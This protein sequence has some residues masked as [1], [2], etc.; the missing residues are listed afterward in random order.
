MHARQ[1]DL[2]GAVVGEHRRQH[3]IEVGQRF[4]LLREHQRRLALVDDLLHLLVVVGIACAGLRDHRVLVLGDLRD[5]VLRRRRAQLADERVD[6]GADGAASNTHGDSAAHQLVGQRDQRR[7]V[8]AHDEIVGAPFDRVELFA[9]FGGVDARDGADGRRRGALEVRHKLA[10]H[11][12]HRLWAAVRRRQRQRRGVVVATDGAEAVAVGT[13]PAVDRLVRVTNG[14]QAATTTNRRRQHRALCG[15]KVL[16]FV[17]EQPVDAGQR[18]VQRPRQ[19]DLVVEVDVVEVAQALDEHAAG[20]ADRLVDEGP[21]VSGRVDLELRHQRA[22]RLIAVVDEALFLQLGAGRDQALRLGGTDEL[23]DHADE[24]LFLPA[25]DVLRQT[26]AH[27]A[28]VDVDAAVAGRERAEAERVERA[29]LDVAD[30]RMFDE[31]CVVHGLRRGGRGAA[32][33]AS[34]CGF[35]LDLQRGR[36][37]E[38]EE[39]G[40]RRGGQATQD[41]DQGRALAAASDGVDDE[42]GLCG[43]GIGDPRK[44]GLVLRR[45]GKRHSGL[46]GFRGDWPHAQSRG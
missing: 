25:A 10:G 33:D 19:K 4:R 37:V 32:H 43:C 14:D 20:E 39:C 24:G 17:D 5:E 22:P 36:L 13:T 34:A 3:V 11:L 12:G 28:A 42:R 6:R 7:V 16:R 1:R 27:D 38:G 41:L 18:N 45:D 44:D 46:P 26:L 23:A 40:R 21:I 2:P 31:P 8:A 29:E 9:V 35:G 15:G 30:V